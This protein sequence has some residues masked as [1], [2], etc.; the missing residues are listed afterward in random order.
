MGLLSCD[1][2]PDAA[3]LY[4][5][6]GSIASWVT[7]ITRSRVTVITALAPRL[8]SNRTHFIRTW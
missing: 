2:L 1:S 8:V 3:N 6:T 7:L 5:S 4:K